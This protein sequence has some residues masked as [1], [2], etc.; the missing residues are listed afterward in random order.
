ME[1]FK[2]WVILLVGSV[3]LIGSWNTIISDPSEDD[4][5]DWVY[6]SER[7]TQLTQSPIF[8]SSS[9]ISTVMSSCGVVVCILQKNKYTFAVETVLILSMTALWCF[10]NGTL[11]FVSF[12]NEE[13][14]SLNFPMTFPQLYF[15][16]WGLTITSVMN[17][18]SWFKQQMRRDDQPLTMQWVLL[19][20][21]GAFVAL[22]GIAFSN[23]HVEDV[24]VVTG[25]VTATPVCRTATYSCTSL[26]FTIILGATTTAIAGAILLYRSSPLKCQAD[27]AMLLVVSWSCGVAIITFPSGPGVSMGTLYFASW[28][29]FFLVLRIL[30]VSMSAGAES[31][32]TS[33]QI[34]DTEKDKRADV[35]NR[36]DLLNVAYDQLENLAQF[37][38]EGDVRDDSASY[39]SSVEGSWSFVDQSCINE[40]SPG[41]E[42]ANRPAARVIERNRL[43]LWAIHIV[44]S[45]VSLAS[46]FPTLPDKSEAGDLKRIVLVIPSLSLAVGCFGFLACTAVYRKLEITLILLS[47]ATWIVG[48]P[49]ISKMSEGSNVDYLLASTNVVFASMGTL[50]MSLLLVTSW[51]KASVTTT[52]WFLISVLSA[53]LALSSY[54]YFTQEVSI[55]TDGGMIS[56]VPRCETIGEGMCEEIRHT[57]Y[58]GIASSVVGIAMVFS[59]LCRLPALFDVFVACLLFGSWGK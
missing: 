6:Y 19:V 29:C 51:F 50:L 10:T 55:E 43:E 34:Q 40:N 47:A 13:K 37:G 23:Q 27:I 36:G 16:S 12:Y 44:G 59:C 2:Y 18:A 52:D 26:R 15:I 38:G 32:T 46:L 57:I 53:I 25:V 35:V 22:S 42:E 48:L 8:V 17:F 58:L 49:F 54:F 11:I 3:L 1:R 28:G 56:E 4:G 39:F 33:T 9:L 20:A 7:N 41:S 31:T 45:I 14:T 30:A 24:D 21:T 5:T